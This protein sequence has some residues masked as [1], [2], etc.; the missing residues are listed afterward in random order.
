M[1]LQ[2]EERTAEIVVVGAGIAGASTAF[3]LSRAGFEPLVIERLDGPAGATT[4]ASA[5]SVRAQFGEPE[6]IRMMRE[7][8]D[9][10]GHF[11]QILGISAEEGDIGFRRGGYLFASTRP[12][13]PA[14]I[15][16]RVAAQHAEGLDDVEL[17]LPDDIQRRFPWMD[18]AITAASYRG[19]DGWV[20]G[21]RATELLIAASGAAVLFGTEVLE[22]VTASG[23]VTGVR[24]RHGTVATDTVVVAAGPFTPVLAPE[25]LPLALVRRHRLI[26]DPRPEV[27]AEA[28]MTVDADTGAHWRPHAGGALLAW[29]RPDAAGPPL[30]PVA[31]DPGFPAMVLRDQEGVARLA[32]FWHD[33]AP[34]LSPRELHLTAGQYAI[35]PDHMPIIGQ[36]AAT[37]GLWFHTGYSGHGIMG[38]PSGGRLLADL[39]RGQS[40]T[41]SNPFRLERFADGLEPV[42][43]ERMVL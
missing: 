31:P 22:V 34:R 10:Y 16:R 17:L 8:L 6:N 35:T 5:H 18:A 26:L 15:E 37:E 19:D 21:V 42:D 38:S 14:L 33:L 27:P 23:R 9:I 40:S 20:D 28:P 11:A 30:W 43:L 12:E 3:W 24:T 13:A 1:D 2:V 4:A 29:P 39:V 25:P 32:P 7:S 36:A 41:E